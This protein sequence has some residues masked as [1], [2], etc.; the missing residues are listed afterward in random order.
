MFSIV[1]HKTFRQRSI[2]NIIREIKNNNDLFGVKEYFIV[3]DTSTH[4]MEYAKKF[5]IE[6]TKIN[7]KVSWSCTTH[8]NFL[9]KELLKLMKKAGCHSIHIGVE[10]GNKRILRLINKQTSL[11]QIIEKSALIK[12]SG[13]KLKTFFMVG[14]PGETISDIR[15]SKDMIEELN[16]DESM[17]HVYI[18][19]PNTRM[20]KH[21][22][23]KYPNFRSIDWISF[24]RIGL[25]ANEYMGNDIN[26]HDDFKREAENFFKFIEEYEQK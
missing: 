19:Y 23:E 14:F 4:D 2:E 1:K 15:N 25:K 17:L 16:A 12:K 9:N 18:P 6:L 20:Y 7:F 3:D 8:V 24:R 13:M 11:S 22:Q 10:T 26:T 5:C 21:I